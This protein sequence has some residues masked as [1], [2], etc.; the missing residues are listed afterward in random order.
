MKHKTKILYI[1]HDE[2]LHRQFCEV[3]KNNDYEIKTAS[4]GKEALGLLE[5]FPADLVFTAQSIPDI[6]GNEI[7]NEIHAS[8]PDIF[9]VFV[10]NCSDV[11]T[12]VRAI[13]DGAYDYILKPFICNELCAV[14]QRVTEQKTLLN[15]LE[16]GYSDD[17]RRKNDRFENFVGRNK[18]MYKLYQTI[19]YIANTNSTVL[20]TG[21]SGTGKE[22]VADAIHFRSK[23]REDSFV[24]VNCATFTETLINSELF[25]HEKGAFTGAVSMKKGLFELADKGTLFLDEIGEMPLPQ[26]SFFLRILESGTFQR[27]GGTQTITVD[28][29][30]ICATNRDL[31]S[32]MDEKMFREDLLYRLSVVT[33]EIPPLRARKSDIPIL[34]RHF[35]K[36]HC[37][38]IG[39][40]VTC[41]SPAAMA[42]M[43]QYDWPGNVRELSNCV[44]R[45]LIFCKGKTIEPED[46]TGMITPAEK[47]HSG[48]FQLLLDSYSL[49]NAEAELIGNVLEKT[50]GNLKQAAQLLDIARGTL[51]SKIKKYGIQRPID[52]L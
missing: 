29:R 11:K 25:G 15:D 40:T 2:S 41:F 16:G 51:Y 31:K 4:R 42:M 10:T 38:Q 49:S 48:E 7:L 34:V 26:Q 33:L 13:K 5:N 14:V 21:E 1:D 43:A 32:A 46:L 35:L 19:D 52:P 50:N 37:K 9:V 36:K 39:K 20:I 24:K 17:E 18:K 6:R 45:A 44:E 28:P 47:T 12:A 22:L 30:L 8:Y 27:V 3:L 23:R